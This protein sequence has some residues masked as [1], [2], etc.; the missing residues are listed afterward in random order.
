MFKAIWWEIRLLHCLQASC[1]QFEMCWQ[2]LS[3][4]GKTLNLK[5]MIKLHLKELQTSWLQ[6]SFSFGKE[7]PSQWLGK[8]RSKKNYWSVYSW[9]WIEI[10]KLEEDWRK[11]W[12]TELIQT[13]NWKIVWYYTL[14]PGS[15]FEIEP[16]EFLTLIPRVWIFPFNCLLCHWHGVNSSKSSLGSFAASSPRWITVTAFASSS[17]LFFLLSSPCFFSWAPFIRLVTTSLAP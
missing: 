15:S 12:K 8:T 5:E 6:K 10:E 9:L 7:Q 1:L 13:I 3:E 2:E 17:C 11:P 14:Q 16:Q 4:S